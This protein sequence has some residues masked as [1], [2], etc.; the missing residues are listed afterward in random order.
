MPKRIQR[1]RDAG[2]RKPEGALFVGR[3][4]IWGNPY[5]VVRQGKTTWH[6][7]AFDA[8]EPMVSFT[9]RTG[10]EARQFAVDRLIDLFTHHRD[11]WGRD[12]VRSELA[13]RDL[14][15]WC[16]EGQARHADAL[17]ETANGGES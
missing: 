4:S 5:R 8:S 9:S 10:R 3:P 14:L 16:P 17:P 13:G 2:W 12:R 11:P 7:Y 6:V 1:R 15:R